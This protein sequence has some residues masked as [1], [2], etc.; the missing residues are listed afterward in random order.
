MWCSYNYRCLLTNCLHGKT[1]HVY[2]CLLTICL[3]GKTAELCLANSGNNRVTTTKYMSTS[4]ASTVGVH[5]TRYS[6]YHVVL[7][8]FYFVVK[9]RS[10]LHLINTLIDTFFSSKLW[11]FLVQQRR[12]RKASVVKRKLNGTVD[13]FS[14]DRK[15]RKSDATVHNL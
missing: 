14:A 1:A 2:R 11:A 4:I 3:H 6:F 5:S 10:R 9:T 13:E 15:I 8:K 7:V 12:K